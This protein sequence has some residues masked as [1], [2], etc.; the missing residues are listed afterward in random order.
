MSSEAGEETELGQAEP[1]P[2]SVFDNRSAHW[3]EGGKQV[4]AKEEIVTRRMHTPLD[5]LTPK[6]SGRRSQTRTDRTRGRDIQSRPARAPPDAIPLD[7]TFPPAA[8]HQ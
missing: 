6:A 4:E 5:R 7:P 1:A 2:Q 8:P 3:W